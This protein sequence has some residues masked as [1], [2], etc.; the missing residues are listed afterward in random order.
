MSKKG[1]SLSLEVIAVFIIMLIALIVIA[2]FVIKNNS[3]LFQ[4]L[5][6]ISNASA[7]LVSNS[8][9]PKP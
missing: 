1:F 2:Y 8:N 3:S 7:E 6:K 9:I 4:S 5:F